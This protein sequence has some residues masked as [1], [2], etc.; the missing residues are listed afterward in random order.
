MWTSC[1]VA[2][3]PTKRVTGAPGKV[4]GVLVVWGMWK[5]NGVYLPFVF[6]EGELVATA[7]E[8]GCGFR[9]AWE[10][11]SQGCS[12]FSGRSQMMTYRGRRLRGFA[13][14]VGGR[15]WGVVWGG[16][17]CWRWTTY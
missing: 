15:V 7:C 11:R 4:L 9:F 17:G 1:L 5:R 10:V 2:F 6:Y 3:G 8:A 12:A 16:G 14:G 13:H